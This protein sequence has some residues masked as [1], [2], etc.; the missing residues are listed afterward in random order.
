MESSWGRQSGGGIKP[1][2]AIA[3]LSAVALVSLG[4]VMVATNPTQ[5][6]YETYATHQV[7]TLLNREVCAD[8]PQAFGVQNECKTFVHA[9]QGDIQK[10]IADRTQQRNFVFFSVYTTDVSVGSFLPNYRV[11]TVGMFRR[12][13]VYE[14]F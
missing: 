3:G 4:A 7:V 10:L 11:Q 6:A 2:S 14:T 9:H 1:K 8:A 12:F 5:A 13:Y